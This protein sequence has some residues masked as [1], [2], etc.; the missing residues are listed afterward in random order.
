LMQKLKEAPN[1]QLPHSV[2]LKR[3]KID[4]RTF[5]EIITTLEQQGDVAIVSQATTGRPQRAYQLV[6]DGSAG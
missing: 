6:D 3:M 4:A 1:Q 5:Q 2:L